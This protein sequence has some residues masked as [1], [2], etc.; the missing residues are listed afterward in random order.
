LPLDV[1]AERLNRERAPSGL[2]LEE[3]RSLLDDGGGGKLS[4]GGGSL[5]LRP[6]MGDITVIALN[7]LAYSAASVAGGLG[8]DVCSEGGLRVSGCA[9]GLLR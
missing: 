4:G 3:E 6:V 8:N 1:N 2:D 5:R 7:G 9:L